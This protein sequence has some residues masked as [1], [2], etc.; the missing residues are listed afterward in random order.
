MFTC[1]HCNMRYIGETQRNLSLRIPE[2]LGLSPRTGKPIGKPSHSNIR[3]HALQMK[4]PC[5]K[6]DFSILHKARNYLDLPILESLYIKHLSP[7][8]NSNLSSC[9]LLTFK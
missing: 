7:E 8:L 4:H 5:N 2:H 1:L 9:T 3:S 6:G